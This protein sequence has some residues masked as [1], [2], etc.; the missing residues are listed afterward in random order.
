[1]KLPAVAVA[2]VALGLAGIAWADDNRA[3]VDQDGS[4]N[5][6]AV[7]QSGGDHNRFGRASDPALQ[8]GN[9]NS[10]EVTQSGDGNRIGRAAP[11]FDQ[12][13][14]LNR[15]KL[16]QG[17]DG[18]RI[19]SVQ[20]SSGGGA[21]PGWR[22][23]LTI[24]QKGGDGNRVGAV[25]QTND[26]ASADDAHT[27]ST[28][29]TQS[30][31]GNLVGLISQDGRDDTVRVR[32]AGGDGNAVGVVYQQGDHSTARLSFNGAGNGTH[33]FSSPGFAGLAAAYALVR[34]GSVYQLGDHDEVHAE[35]VGNR[36][37]FGFGQLGDRNDA[38]A[39]VTGDRNG[40]AI[41]TGGNDNTGRITIDG[42]RNEAGILQAPLFVPLWGHLVPW[43]AD[44]NSAEIAIDGGR[45]AVGVVQQ[46]I[47]NTAT[48]GVTSPG[49][50]YNLIDV[51]LASLYCGTTAKA[52]ANGTGNV[53]AIDQAGANTARVTADGNA[54][55]VEVTQGPRA[56]VADNSAKVAITGSSNALVIDQQGKN[57][58]DLDLFGSG[59]N[60]TAG[61]G[62]GP[63]GGFT[64]TA[65]AAATAGSLTPGLI[66]QI[67]FGNSIDLTV[68]TATADADDNLF[69]FGQHGTGN[70][71]DGTIK[72]GSNQAAVVQA[73]NWNTI[74]FR[75]LGVGNVMG[76]LQ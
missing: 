23:T 24:V 50:G 46:G 42:N 27:N 29:I 37:S 51:N 70:R 53:I 16:A 38:R 11:G 63:S 57:E 66:S 58:L 15:A 2:V 13:G 71:I 76:A 73:G 18:N 36:N 33:G 67:G 41:A 31:G 32:Q 75:Q 64:G 55:L 69:A 20:Q 7:D 65:L 6:G 59:N 9:G 39:D 14:D 44:D 47:G 3:Y 72:G 60:N 74:H 28:R 10:V 34:E 17:S 21:A 19:G 8:E 48:V 68:G 62:L 56:V 4:F 22:N 35:V 5:V 1:M 61:G 25:G 26:S 49:H 54:N 40:V 43:G 45:N 30:S 52:K 12:D